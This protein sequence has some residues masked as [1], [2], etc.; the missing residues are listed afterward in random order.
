MFFCGGLAKC[1]GFKTIVRLA[2]ES[3]TSPT[4]DDM[5]RKNLTANNCSRKV[6]S[7]K[8]VFTTLLVIIILFPTVSLSFAGGA[9][10]HRAQARMRKAA[11]VEA[12]KHAEFWKKFDDEMAKAQQEFDEADTKHPKSSGKKGQVN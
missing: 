9:S 12:E 5:D 8:Q 6:P 10:W 1:V 3:A 7:M 4:M 2:V 11:R